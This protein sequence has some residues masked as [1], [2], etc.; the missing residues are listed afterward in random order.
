M[1]FQFEKLGSINKAELELGDLTIICGENN[2]GKTYV[3]YAIYG[4]LA[5]WNKFINFELSQ[6]KIDNLL[7][8]GILK[9]DL[10]QFE[11]NIFSLINELSR[12][13][14][15]LIIP[16]IFSANEGYFSKTSFEVFINYNPSYKNELQFSAKTKEKEVLKAFKEK[17]SAILEITLLVENE[18]L[19]PSTHIV[20]DFIAKALGKALLGHYF[21]SPF[22]ITAE[23]IGISLFYRELDI[24]KNVLVEQLQKQSKKFEIFDFFEMVNNTVSRYALPIQNNID[25][26]RD[27]FDIHSKKTSP[28]LKEHPEF[29]KDLKNILGGEIKVANDQ[30][31]FT[32]KQARKN[33]TIP[34]YLSSSTVK[35]LLDLNFYIKH[36][37][38][39]GDILFID[40]P[41]LNL[42]P[43]NQRKM[44]RLFVRLIKAGIKVF[45][46]TH[47]DYII[48]ELN[49][50][51]ILGNKFEERNKIMK[52][53]KYTEADV[54]DPTSVKVY[55]AENQT[56][57][58]APIDN[59]GI[60]VKSFDKEIEEMKNMFDD[61]T[62]TMEMAYEL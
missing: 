27:I 52:K 53:Y 36:I 10:N 47:S 41:E 49:N 12:D 22:I 62:E 15:Q 11:N 51:I 8:E 60:A 55:I 18:A 57:T 38:K 59:L 45:I 54:L 16:Q 32:F 56:L 9:I 5:T 40:E 13:Y 23:R 6:E 28:L 14:T 21:A 3:S 34:L 25:F 17:S 35:S 20:K 42:H 43:A 37:A 24:S 30:I 46:T 1:K 7:K 29:A 50:L 19:I 58:P 39:S 2:T 31:F 44:A 61:M 26:V 48:K 4:F 33:Q